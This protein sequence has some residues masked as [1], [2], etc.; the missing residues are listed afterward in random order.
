MNDIT[1]TYEIISVD[2]AARVMEVVYTSPDYGIMHVGARLPYQ[3][4]TVEQVVAMF[5]PVQEWRLRDLQVV[6][7][8]VGA[9]GEITDAEPDPLPIEDQVRLARSAAYT[10]EADPIFFKWQRGEATEQEWLD[11]IE[12]IR[13]R[14]PYPDEVE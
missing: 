4:E 2:E 11:K 12:E 1:Y 3:G 7:P 14:Y 13:A 8:G 6:V 9:S 5:A 10:A